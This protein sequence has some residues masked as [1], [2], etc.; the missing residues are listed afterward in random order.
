MVG[1]GRMTEQLYDI[2]SRERLDTPDRVKR[3]IMH[4]KTVGEIQE[5]RLRLSQ[6]IP[7]IHPRETGQ[8]G[9]FRFLP[10]MDIAAHGSG[11]C[12]E[13]ACRLDRIDR[14]L[15]FA[16]LWADLVVLPSYVSH[17]SEDIAPSDVDEPNFRNVIAGDLQ[18]MLACRPLVEAGIVAWAS[19]AYYFCPHCGHEILGQLGAAPGVARAIQRLHRACVEKAK[20][21]FECHPALPLH[22]RYLVDIQGPEDVVPHGRALWMTGHLPQWLPKRVADRA[23]SGLAV[24][25]TLARSRVRH[26]ERLM[27][28]LSRV[29]DDIAAQHVMSTALGTRYL[30]NRQ[31]DTVFLQALGENPEHER[32]NRIIGQYLSYEIPIIE[33]VSLSDLLR[34]RRDD[35]EAFLVY[36]D[37]LKRVIDE[38]IVPERRLTG[39]EAKQLFEDVI[40]PNLNRMDA[41]VSSIRKK[42]ARKLARDVVVTGTVLSAGLFTG[43]VP[44]QMI[45]L[46]SAL[47]GLPVARELVTTLSSAIGTPDEVRGEDL[48]FLWQVRRRARRRA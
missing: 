27:H 40:R 35:H 5:L 2:L 17:C 32:L 7:D 43:L 8:R 42:A 15:R 45:G 28:L 11:F 9:P 18:V 20:V 36:R 19:R 33:S 1:V 10:N 4:D 13:W 31:V 16:A 25:H 44:A 34:V 12:H 30:T 38:N 46:L 39:T 22:D 6:A 47:G 41:K 3:A 24:E 37:T 14:L 29:A 48:Y 26:V 23:A 21:R